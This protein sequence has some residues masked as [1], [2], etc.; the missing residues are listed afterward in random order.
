MLS[1]YSDPP[2]DIKQL[3]SLSTYGPAIIGEKKPHLEYM[4]DLMKGLETGR[5]VHM[6]AE[7]VINQ[8]EVSYQHYCV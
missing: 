6:T 2:A 5:A 8:Q 3:S 1:G 4:E 7:S